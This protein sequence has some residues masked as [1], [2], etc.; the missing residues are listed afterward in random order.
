MSKQTPD[1]ADPRANQ[2]IKAGWENTPGHKAFK[3]VKLWW[4]E[5]KEPDAMTY[6]TLAVVLLLAFAIYFY[7]RL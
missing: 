1:P 6:F 7:V 5:G 2:R 3:D 4:R